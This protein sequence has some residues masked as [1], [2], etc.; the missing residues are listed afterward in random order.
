MNCKRCKISDRI[1]SQGC[2]YEERAMAKKF[3]FKPVKVNRQP[4]KRG[5]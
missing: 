4:R 2:F 1:C 5:K 3:H